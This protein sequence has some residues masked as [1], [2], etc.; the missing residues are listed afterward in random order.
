MDNPTLSAPVVVILGLL[1]PLIISALKRAGSSPVVNQLVAIVVSIV[2]GA[3]SVVIDSGGFG[4]FD[5]PHVLAFSTG[6]FAV[7]QVIYQTYFH[8][9]DFNKRLTRLIWG[10]SSVP[11]S[12]LGGAAL[13]T[14]AGGNTNGGGSSALPGG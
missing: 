7:A 2:L 14:T 11:A 10:V 13:S 8:E 5:V 9:T 6:V 4:T 12:R 1:A 3:A